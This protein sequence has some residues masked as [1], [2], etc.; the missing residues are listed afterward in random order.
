MDRFPP[1]EDRVILA[2]DATRDRGGWRR[3]VGSVRTLISRLGRVSPGTV[4]RILALLGTAGAL[5]DA[6][7]QPHIDMN[8]LAIASLVLLMGS[9]GWRRVNSAFATVVAIS[10]LITFTYASGYN[11]DGSF[12]AVAIALNF[13]LLGQDARTHRGTY[14]RVVVLG[15]WVVGAVVVTYGSAPGTPGTVAGVWCLFGVLPFMSGSCLP[16]ARS[17]TSS[18][19]SRPRGWMANRR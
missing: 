5:S 12:E 16:S 9:I 7:S 6:F 11:G 14:W 3:D 8:A 4:D 13:Y 15:Y 2:K 19:R 18:L 17:R 1:G 10:A